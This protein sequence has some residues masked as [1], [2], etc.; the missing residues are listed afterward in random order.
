ML[1]CM[2]GEPRGAGRDAAHVREQRAGN[3]VFGMRE[4]ERWS[5]HKQLIDFLDELFNAE[6]SAS[7][8]LQR[9]LSVE[10]AQG[11]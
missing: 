10:P 2:D 4:A 11:C 8:K 7:T 5:G 3:R 9:P 6:K 1:D